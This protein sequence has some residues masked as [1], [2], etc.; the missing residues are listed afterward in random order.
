MMPE[1]DGMT[2][3]SELRA[4]PEWVDIPVIAITAKTLTEDDKRHLN[5]HAE[6]VLLKAENSPAALVKQIRGILDK[7]QPVS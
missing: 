3:L 4:K 6:R 2:F 5:A 7:H 1:M